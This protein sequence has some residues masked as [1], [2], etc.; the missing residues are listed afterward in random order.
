LISAINKKKR[1][2]FAKLHLHQPVSFCENVILSD[3]S[4]YNIFGHDGPSKV[5]RKNKA[6]KEKKFDP[7][8]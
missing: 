3:E 5:W 8:R 6:M 2:E 7:N 1:L 4:K